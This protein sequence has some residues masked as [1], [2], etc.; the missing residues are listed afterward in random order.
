MSSADRRICTS[1]RRSIA[2]RLS[3]KHSQSEGPF[4][5]VTG[6][7]RSRKLEREP[8][9]M[10]SNGDVAV[11]RGALALPRTGSEEHMTDFLTS[12]PLRLA[13]DDASYLAC[14]GAT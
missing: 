3:S 11:D 7:V 14:A 12:T 9:T 8:Q 4:A 2:V 6:S 13:S 5:E 10:H 1:A